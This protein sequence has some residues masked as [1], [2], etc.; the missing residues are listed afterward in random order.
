MEKNAK[1]IF[2]TTVLR[3]HISHFKGGPALPIAPRHH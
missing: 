1:Y 3:T 2:P